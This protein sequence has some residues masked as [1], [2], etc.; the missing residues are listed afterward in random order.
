[1]R[2]EGLCPLPFLVMALN[3]IQITS[4]NSYVFSKTRT[5]RYLRLPT[6]SLISQVRFY[7]NWK[8]LKSFH[9]ISVILWFNVHQ[10]VQLVQLW[11]RRCPSLHVW[12]YIRREIQRNKIMDIFWRTKTIFQRYVLSLKWH[13]VRSALFQVLF[14]FTRT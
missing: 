13:S 12:I 3:L 10:I 2:P 11:Q 6:I 8:T 1:M 14:Q 9:L 5:S 7:V 4:H